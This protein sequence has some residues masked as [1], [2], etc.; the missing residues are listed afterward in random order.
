MRES[1]LQKKCKD[2]V[3]KRG[4]LVN[5][6]HGGPMQKSGIP[7]LLICYCGYYIGCELKVGYNKCSENQKIE[8]RKTYE[9]GGIAVVVRDS[10]DLLIKILDM[11]DEGRT[12]NDI[13]Q[14]LPVPETSSSGLGKRKSALS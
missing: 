6:I 1:L 12:V 14:T 13:R 11:I 4:G 3:E 9:S 10:P 5:N 7:D 8:L 2:I